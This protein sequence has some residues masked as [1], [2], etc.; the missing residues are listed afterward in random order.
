MECISRRRVHSGT[1]PIA[2][3]AAIVMIAGFA[4]TIN[5]PLP[6]RVLDVDDALHGHIIASQYPVDANVTIINYSAPR[7]TWSEPVTF[8]FFV[9]SNITTSM[10]VYVNSTVLV[11]VVRAVSVTAGV[12]TLVLNLDVLPL[13]QTG[14]HEITIRFEHG[15]GNAT[16][17]HEMWVGSNTIISYGILFGTIGACIVIYAV[18]G[19]P[20]KP[21]SSAPGLAGTAPGASDDDTSTVTY[22]DQ[23]QAPPGRIYCP[24]C[25]KVIEEG[26]I[27]CPECGTRIPRYL[28]YHP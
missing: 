10:F 7:F 11:P 27:F 8:R 9:D 12:T 24:E 18:V 2:T 19:A 14:L 26:S 6:A 15:T 21:K 5:A 1:L 17:T 3:I 25:K 13:A 16:I 28:R 4:M 23:S 22:V 20:K